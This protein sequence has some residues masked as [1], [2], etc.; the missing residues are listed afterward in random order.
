MAPVL[1]CP[2][3]GARHPLDSVG[4]RSAFPCV[5]CGR[6]LKVPAQ[7]RTIAP[8]RAPEMAPAAAAAPPA[9][10]APAAP[11]PAVDPDATRV[12]STTA[13]PL[14]KTA[15]AAPVGVAAAGVTPAGIATP[16]GTPIPAP[17]TNGAATTSRLGPLGPVPGRWV[18]FGLWVIAVPLAFVVVFGLARALGLLTTNE[19]TDVALAEG[20]QRFWPIARLVP[21]VALLTAAFVQGGVYAIARFRAKGAPQ[22]RRGSA[23][24]G[25]RQ[26]RQSSTAGR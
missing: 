8:T 6:T 26:T 20:W 24:D 15:A 19:I 2:E 9:P 3:C 5:G 21:F 16:A 22:P 4:L 13:P 23:P 7:A 10:P 17:G 12:F 14:P 1:Q 18:R 25:A 11:A